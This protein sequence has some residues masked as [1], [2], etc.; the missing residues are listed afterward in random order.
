MLGL[1][2]K[3]FLAQSGVAYW[4]KPFDI[5]LPKQQ[6]DAIVTSNEIATNTN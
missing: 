3:G 5:G 2:V 4:A 6:V 1:D